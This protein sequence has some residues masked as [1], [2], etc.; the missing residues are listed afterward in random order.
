[1]RFHPCLFAFA[2]VI[3]VSAC[4]SQRPLESASVRD[5][6]A[7][8]AETSTPSPTTAPPN[9]L[10]AEHQV[11]M[12][13][14]SRR[15]EPF[16]LCG[17]GEEQNIYGSGETDPDI[18]NGLASAEQVADEFLALVRRGVSP[19]NPGLA[20][21]PA[22]ARQAYLDRF[23]K[24][25]GPAKD[26]RVSESRV[27]GSLTVFVEPMDQVDG[28]SETFDAFTWASVRIEVK[29]NQHGLFELSSAVICGRQLYDAAALTDPIDFDSLPNRV[30]TWESEQ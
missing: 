12:F 1:M 7:D 19:E 6:S 9:P 4:G 25:Y 23:E 2:F 8:E 16:A 14:E 11:G 18:Q 5:V 15:G 21:L 30:E 24:Y 27:E 13:T 29:G 26:L 28:S 17:P 3:V 22:E 10:P 20:R